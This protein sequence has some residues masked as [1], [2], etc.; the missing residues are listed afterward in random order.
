MESAVQALIQRVTSLEGSTAQDKATMEESIRLLNQGLQEAGNSHNATH[1]RVELVARELQVTQ[2]RVREIEK[3]Q[4][5]SPE[6]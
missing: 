6:W 3:H 2:A 4:T 5:T 1:E